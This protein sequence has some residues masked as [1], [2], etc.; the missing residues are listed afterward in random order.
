MVIR[1]MTISLSEYTL[2]D[3]N[4]SQLNFCFLVIV[5]L[6]NQPILGILFL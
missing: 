6:S 3:G 2:E 1:E 5:F 4:F